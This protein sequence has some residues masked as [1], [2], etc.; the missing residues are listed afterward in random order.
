MPLP[1]YTFLP[2]AP[3]ASTKTWVWAIVGVFGLGALVMVAIRL[4]RPK[5]KAAAEPGAGNTPPL[6]YPS[7]PDLPTQTPPILP[8]S[9]TPPSSGNNS[10]IP[11]VDVYG[12]NWSYI[13]ELA[14][15]TQSTIYEGKDYMCE[16]T[17]GVLEM[18]DN[19]L[20]AFIAL[21]SNWY[22]R[23][24]QDDYCKHWTTSGCTLSWFE[25]KEKKAC[26]RLRNLQ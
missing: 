8:P 13:Q 3:P 12:T 20:R 9:T 6:P 11:G 25:D 22:N 24:F 14:W 4:L 5:P 1:T 16:V 18:G 23:R 10:S 19:D 7:F 26:T 2:P 15:K 21:Y 17:N